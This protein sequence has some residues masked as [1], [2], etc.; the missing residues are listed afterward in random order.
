MRKHQIVDILLRAG[1]DV[2]IADGYG[3]T[4]LHL[5]ASMPDRELVVLAMV[6][7][8]LRAGAS[9]D[10]RTDSGITP[11]FF[12]VESGRVKVAQALVKAGANPAAPSTKGTPV[13]LAEK[14]GNRAMLAVLRGPAASPR[15]EPRAGAV[16]LASAPPQTV[17][18]ELPFD[19]IWAVL[20]GTA[21]EETHVGYAAY[22]LD[23][24]PAEA[25]ATAVPEARRKKLTDWPCFGRPVLAP[26]DGKVVWARDRSLDPPIN[27]PIKGDTGNFLIIEHAATEFTEFRHLQAKSLLV[28][29]GD[30]VRTGQAIARCG[31]S[32]NAGM[33]HLHMGFLGSVDPIATRPVRF[34]RYQVYQRGNWVAPGTGLPTAGQVVRPMER[35][36]PPAPP[37]SASSAS[38]GNMPAKSR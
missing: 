25:T 22:A 2:T 27:K 19:G 8:I 18:L 6:S 10:S 33:P 13:S 37:P 17:E 14:S 38:S 11:L 32:G 16:A 29:A 9:A 31:N 23:F 15:D 30:R 26:A 35:A 36:T 1:A 5:A 24:V 4:A 7:R 28:K 21:S 20:Q 12:A 3:M 34:S